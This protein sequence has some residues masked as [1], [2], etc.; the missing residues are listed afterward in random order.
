MSDTRPELRPLEYQRFGPVP[1]VPYGHV[2][3]EGIT[4]VQPIMDRFGAA[5]APKLK[6]RRKLRCHYM[7]ES[8][9]LRQW[10]I[11][12]DPGSHMLNFHF[13]R[14]TVFFSWWMELVQ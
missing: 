14:K 12:L 8:L 2:M 11:V 9:A 3:A 13:G 5:M 7:T 4:Q 6:F 10:G 1:T